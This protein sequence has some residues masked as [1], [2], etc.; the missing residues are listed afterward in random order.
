MAAGERIASASPPTLHSSNPAGRH[1]TMSFLRKWHDY[2]PVEVGPTAALTASLKA[3]R[4]R[5]GS[6]YTPLRPVFF[7]H[8]VHPPLL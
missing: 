7:T 3:S 1:V 5:S 8:P 4:G 6:R 2:H